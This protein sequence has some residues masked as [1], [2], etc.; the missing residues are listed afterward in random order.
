MMEI[1]GGESILIRVSEDLSYWELTVLL[2]L[3]LL[4]GFLMCNHMFVYLHIISQG[5]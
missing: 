5:D 1:Q 3:V 2:L 4:V